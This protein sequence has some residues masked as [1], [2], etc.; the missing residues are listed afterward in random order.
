MLLFL[1]QQYASAARQLG[2]IYVLLENLLDDPNA[3][4]LEDQQSVDYQPFERDLL[5]TVL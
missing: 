1:S 5:L 2:S 3:N 4:D